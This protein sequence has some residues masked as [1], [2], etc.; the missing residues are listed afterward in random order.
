MQITSK[1][2]CFPGLEFSHMEITLPLGINTVSALLE[3]NVYVRI[4][5][6]IH[7]FQEIVTEVRNGEHNSP[8]FFLCR[9]LLSPLAVQPSGIS[10]VPSH[11]LNFLFSAFHSVSN[12]IT[13]SPNSACKNTWYKPALSYDA[14]SF[15]R[16]P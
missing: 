12:Q 7:R 4:L 8:H 9:C 2:S 6:R 5:S 10:S 1:M 15:P 3:C 16:K 13:I 11:I 14:I